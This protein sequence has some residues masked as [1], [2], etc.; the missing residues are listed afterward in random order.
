[1]VLTTNFNNIAW[2]SDKGKSVT[3]KVTDRNLGTGK[4]NLN[5]SP[6]AYVASQR[7]CTSGLFTLFH[8]FNKLD[9]IDD[10]TIYG[11]T[12]VQN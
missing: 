10:G 2:I 11:V 3:V 1:M 5:L 8:S 7:S 9:N 12:W 6:T 4:Y